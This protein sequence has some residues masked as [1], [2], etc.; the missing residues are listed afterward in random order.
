VAAGRCDTFLGQRYRRIAR[1]RGQNKAVAAIGRSLLV[2][3]WYLLADPGARDTGLGSD[4][5]APRISPER[6]TRG[7]IRQLEAPGCQVTLEPAA[8]ATA[9][10]S[11]LRRHSAGR[12]RAP[13][14]R[15]FS[16]QSLY[17]CATP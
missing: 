12:C 14:T 17:R 9:P 2:I 15:R 1:R 6:R 13:L 11:R 10:P 16:D 7:H 4:F 8:Y 5:Q 3:I